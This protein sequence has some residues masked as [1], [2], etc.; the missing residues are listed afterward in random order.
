MPSI[1]FVC[2]R[3]ADL[4]QI[5]ETLCRRDSP[6]SWLIA[7]AGVE[8]AP[9]EDPRA[10]EVLRR[11]GLVVSFNKP[12]GFQDLPE[13]EWDFTVF[14]GEGEMPSMPEGRKVIQWQVPDP[15]HAPAQS[16][17]AIFKDLEERVTGLLRFIGEL[18]P[19]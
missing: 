4:S 15:Q 11:H 10:V 18:T 14:L 2:N 7:S 16:C 8:P 3:N 9:Q 19:A 12:R 13:V 6:R 17:D 5:A 1:L